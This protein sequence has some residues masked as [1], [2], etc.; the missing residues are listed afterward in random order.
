MFGEAGDLGAI[1]AVRPH[2]LSLWEAFRK[3]SPR[4]RWRTICTNGPDRSLRH[5]FVMGFGLTM[6]SCAALAQTQAG[7]DFVIAAQ[8]LATALDAYSATSG[9]ELFYDGELVIGR[10]SKAVEGLLAPDAALRELLVGSGLVARA[11]GPNSF[12]I[13]PRPPSRVADSGHQAYFSA[14]QA[15]VAQVLCARPQTRPGKTDLL[16][17]LWIG[18]SGLVQRAQLLDAPGDRLL[19]NLFAAALRG[20]SIGVPPPAGLPQPITMAILARADGEASGCAD[21][22]TMAVR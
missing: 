7:V 9:V 17:R 21:P 4:L 20:V 3:P 10:R 14:I 5:T 19:E 6:L 13:A 11:T 2:R 8:P 16:L 15:R 1:V 18:P 12:T 22:A